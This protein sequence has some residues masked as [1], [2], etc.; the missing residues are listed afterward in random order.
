MKQK[1]KEEIQAEPISNSLV[2]TDDQ[3]AAYR[4]WNGYTKTEP[5]HTTDL[6]ECYTLTKKFWDRIIEP[7]IY[8]RIASNFLYLYAMLNEPPIKTRE[9]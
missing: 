1:R 3:R 5:L 2:I 8:S 7:E 6:H 4:K 9:Y